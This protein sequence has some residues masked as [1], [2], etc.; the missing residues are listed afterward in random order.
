M[1]IEFLL[2]S[3][4]AFGT[5]TIIAYLK[6]FEDGIAELHQQHNLLYC[7]A[8]HFTHQSETECRNP[9][10]KLT[11]LKK[12]YTRKRRATFGYTKRSK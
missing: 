6:Q 11:K 3:I 5:L 1:I 12:Y 2:T 4:A 10:S 9:E 7:P 8:C